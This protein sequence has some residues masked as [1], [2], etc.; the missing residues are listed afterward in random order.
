MDKYKQHDKTIIN[1]HFKELNP[2]VAG[3]QIRHAG[4]SF[5]P[6]IREFYIIHYILSGKGIFKNKN[7]TYT[8]EAGQYFLL[9]IIPK[10]SHRKR[11]FRNVLRRIN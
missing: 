1:R 8:L 7:A 10:R 3:W 2:M 4:A 9:R 5:G 6:T 11:R